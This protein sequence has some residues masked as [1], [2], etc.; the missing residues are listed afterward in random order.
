MLTFKSTASFNKNSVDLS[1]G[2]IW[3]RFW[4]P[5]EEEVGWLRV[6]Y[7]LIFIKNNIQKW[8]MQTPLE[9]DRIGSG[10]K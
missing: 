10:T 8:I 6:K 2:L 4:L 7:Q 1:P 5:V 3:V 9:S